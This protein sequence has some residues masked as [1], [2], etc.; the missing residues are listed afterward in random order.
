M[1]HLT[2]DRLAEAALE[3]SDL[4]SFDEAAHLDECPTCQGELAR[5]RREAAKLLLRNAD[6]Q[7]LQRPGQHLWARIEADLATDHPDA[8]PASTDR[9]DATPATDRPDGPGRAA[10]R[11]RRLRRGLVLLAAAAGLVVGI[12]GTIVAGRVGGGPDVVASTPLVALPGH[13]GSGTAELLRHDGVAELRVQV[14]TE[15]APDQDYRELWLINTDGKRMYSIGVLPP[16]GRE[17]YPI[18]PPARR[19]PRGLHHRRRVP[20][21]VPTVTPDIPSTAWSVGPCRHD[22]DRTGMRSRSR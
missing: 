18:P 10:S 3:D 9:P 21:A 11:P 7:S 6:P 14:D 4:L 19:G 1:V 5:L 20:Q 22:R 13:R 8:T 2:S 12:G 15:T 16:S 17:T